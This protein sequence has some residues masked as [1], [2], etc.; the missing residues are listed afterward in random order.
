MKQCERNAV[1]GKQGR[2]LFLCPILGPGRA[3][4]ARV[5]GGI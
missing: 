4:K 3:E 5:L 2:E 1:I